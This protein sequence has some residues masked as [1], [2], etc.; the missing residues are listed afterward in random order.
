[1]PLLLVVILAAV[2]CRKKDLPAPVAPVIDT[3]V[4]VKKGTLK[5][6]VNNVVGMQPL[7]FGTAYTTPGGETFT[8]STYNYYL[9]NFVFTDDKGNRFTE[10]ES[11]HLAKAGAG[12]NT[13]LSFEVKDVPAANYTAVEFLIGVDSIRNVSGAQ[14]GALSPDNEMFWSWSTG[15]IMAKL[16]GKLQ[17]SNTMISMHIAGFKGTY[18]VLQKV[19]LTLPVSAVVSNAK[20]TELS[21]QSDLMKWFAAPNFT[22]F[23]EC[24][25][26]GSSGALALRIAQNYSAMMSVQSV[27]NP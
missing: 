10:P 12:G 27:K 6:Q 26:I 1:M 2:S 25:S 19:K 7:A 16:E 13:A 17:P 11:Y 21:L 5:I 8:V 18:N 22:N 4:T 3:P 9:S 14:S 15:Y 23:A 24:G 20:T